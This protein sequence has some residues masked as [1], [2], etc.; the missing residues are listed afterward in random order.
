MSGDDKVVLLLRSLPPE[1][2]EP[3]LA[4]LELADAVR[5]RARLQQPAPSKAPG[6]L[7][8]VAREF[9]DVARIV[10]RAL[11]APAPPV[12]PTAVTPQPPPLAPS[13]QLAMAP[14]PPPPQTPP[15]DPTAAIREF[16]PETLAAALRSERPTTVALVL[17]QLELSQAS[18][19]LKLLPAEVRRE[20][21][22]RQVQSVS[23]PPDLMRRILEGIAARCRILAATPGR[24][25]G[26]DD[27][28]R[29][30]DLIRSLDREDRLEIT[31]RLERK[32]PTK[33]DKVRKLLYR[34]SDVL[35]LDDRTLQTVLGN[36]EVKSLALALKGAPEETQS[37]ILNNVSRR[38]RDN[39]NEEMELLGSSVQPAQIEDARQTIA[40]TL[41]QLDEE[42]K[43][44]M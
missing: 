23:L 35:R 13:Q 33:A 29:L 22:A 12:A 30:A 8:D 40:D 43:L 4:R 9:S 36:L 20:A 10:G 21:V 19:V 5:L 6:S 26:E 1:A 15:S 16:T 44:S 42:G 38:V 37:K 32:D 11:A 31:G 39:V 3:I 27:V 2:V 24:S 17:A 18:A 25:G 34:F 28:V 14:D 41:R 7:A